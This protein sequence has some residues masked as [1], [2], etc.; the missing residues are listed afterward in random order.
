MKKLPGLFL[1]RHRDLF[2]NHK[3]VVV[4]PALVI[5]A[6][7]NT[8]GST[9]IARR[10]EAGIAGIQHVLHGNLGS[11]RD[12]VGKL[13]LRDIGPGHDFDHAKTRVVLTP[14]VHR[15]TVRL[16]AICTRLQ[17][18]QDWQLRVLQR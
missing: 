5:I 15:L 1:Q 11:G 4:L 17:R 18:F 12:G 14:L 3:I 2:L 10:I 16:V 6:A 7:R 8:A 13:P 9:R